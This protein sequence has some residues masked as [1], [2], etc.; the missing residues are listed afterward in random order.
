MNFAFTYVET[1]D[2]LQ[3]G[4]PLSNIADEELAIT[5]NGVTHDVHDRIARLN[6]FPDARAALEQAGQ[7][8]PPTRAKLVPDLWVR[9]NA[10]EALSAE[11]EAIMT[12]NSFY[13][14]ETL[15]AEQ[16]RR[17]AGKPN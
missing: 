17:T 10:G 4:D 13:M 11:Q 8:D 2:R 14:L 3:A 9:E 1:I 5:I 16:E 6:R 15:K 12:L 7:F